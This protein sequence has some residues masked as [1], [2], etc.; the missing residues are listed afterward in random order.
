MSS[1]FDA[2]DTRQRIEDR[3]EPLRFSYRLFGDPLAFAL[4]RRDTQIVEIGMPPRERRA[5]FMCDIVGHAAHRFNG[6]L[7]PPQHLVE[8]SGELVEI[9]TG[10]A[11]RNAFG[12]V[13]RHY[14]AR[15]LRNGTDAAAAQPASNEFSV[16]VAPRGYCERSL[17]RPQ[18]QGDIPPGGCHYP[19]TGAGPLYFGP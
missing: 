17:P 1:A 2:R 18:T 4:V 15:G 14:P 7:N 11:E 19:L 9:V 5:Q 16:M 12:E 6:L 3:L 10:V 8:R 13:A